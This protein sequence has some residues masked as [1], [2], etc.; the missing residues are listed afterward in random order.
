[1]GERILRIVNERGKMHNPATNSGGMLIGR[2]KDAGR[3]REKIVLGEQII[4]LTSLSTI[5]LYLESIKEIKGDL[6]YVQ[7]KAILFQ[8][9][10]FAK[11]PKEYEQN[12]MSLLSALD[13]SSIVPQVYRTVKD[14]DTVLVIGTGKAGTTA[15]AAIRRKFK[16]AHI[17]TTDVS[18]HALDAAIELGYA[19]Q[20]LQLNARRH[21]DFFRAIE[22]ETSGG[23]C[24]VV[25]NCVN[26][27]DTEASSVLAIKER[28]K[29]LLFSMATR[30]DKAA[31]A[32]D[33]TGKDVDIII[34][35]GIAE[36]QAEEMLK[37][38]KEDSKLKKC[39]EQHH[40]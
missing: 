19:D 38:L 27:G 7:G 39:F 11:V 1:M 32:T 25:I 6:V 4:P 3:G 31:L 13:I 17:I 16:Q 29:V 35:N 9:A 10:P 20:Y 30:F 15:A 34:G 36:M 5:P 33:A 26:T 8:S 37:L 14:C 21:E 22:N 18:T 12:P 2:I 40:K 28:G 24:D 23:L